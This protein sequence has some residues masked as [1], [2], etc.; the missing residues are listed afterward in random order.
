MR[1]LIL[2]AH[3]MVNFAHTRT[4]SDVGEKDFQERLIRD[5]EKQ[6]L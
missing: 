1:E 6:A 4:K 5:P 2:L 3:G